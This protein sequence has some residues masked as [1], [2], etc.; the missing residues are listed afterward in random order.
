MPDPMT[1]REQLLKAM[2]EGMFRAE[3][4]SSFWSRDDGVKLATAALE[5]IEARGAIICPAKPTEE[6]ARAYWYESDVAVRLGL[7][8]AIAASPYRKPETP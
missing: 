2:A 3:P 4:W 7:A 1:P 8:K 6:M 5:A